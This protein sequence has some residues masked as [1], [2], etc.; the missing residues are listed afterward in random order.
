MTLACNPV[1]FFT[2]KKSKVASGKAAFQRS[3]AK[4]A[5]SGSQT[6]TATESVSLCARM[7]C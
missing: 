3:I 2:N 6:L 5:Q 1:R 4:G 7:T